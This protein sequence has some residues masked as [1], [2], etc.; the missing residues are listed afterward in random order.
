MV[1]EERV[2]GYGSFAERWEGN[3]GDWV[4]IEDAREQLG[5]G[6][7]DGE[8]AAKVRCTFEEEMM[9]MFVGG[10]GDVPGIA[11]SNHVVE[12]DAKC[13]YVGC[14]SSVGPLFCRD[15]KAFCYPFRRSELKSAD[16]RVE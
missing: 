6:L 3:A 2:D 16:E 12:D 8:C 15:S 13:P 11:P 10:Q 4:G 1:A 9:E 5:G 7:G 14:G